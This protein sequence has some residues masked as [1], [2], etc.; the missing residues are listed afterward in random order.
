VQGYQEMANA[1]VDALN[2]TYGFA[3]PVNPQ[4]VLTPAQVCQ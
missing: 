3:I 2:A 1:A 4:A